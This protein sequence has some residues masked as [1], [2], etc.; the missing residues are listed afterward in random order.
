MHVVQI[1]SGSQNEIPFKNTCEEKATSS[2][3]M[4]L[5]GADIMTLCTLVVPCA[6][7]LQYQYIDYHSWSAG[8]DWRVQSHS[9]TMMPLVFARRILRVH[10]VAVSY[11]LVRVMC[12]HVL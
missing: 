12:T 10:V 2:A 5:A 6:L 4:L 3:Q 11:V 7:V 8:A 1:G 9:F